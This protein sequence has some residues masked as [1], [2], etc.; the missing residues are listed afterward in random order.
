MSGAGGESGVNAAHNFSL[1]ICRA[2]NKGRVSSSV[3]HLRERCNSVYAC[4][5]TFRR[6]AVS[7][8]TRSL[9]I[10]MPGDSRLFSLGFGLLGLLL[11][12]MRP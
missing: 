9:A 10:E 2:N 1:G 8:A 4:H 6:R 7:A 5:R 3:M 12:L 11:L